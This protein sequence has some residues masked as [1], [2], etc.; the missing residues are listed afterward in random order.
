MA[1]AIAAATDKVTHS[2]VAVTSLTVGAA[3]RR[4]SVIARRLAATVVVKYTVTFPAG[5]TA[6]ALTSAS[7]NNTKLAEQIKS[8]AKAQGLTI[9]VSDVTVQPIVLTSAGGST[10][11]PT[12]SST[13]SETSPSV[14]HF[15]SIGITMVAMMSLMH[16]R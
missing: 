7:M 3:G 13:G 16:S 1:H 11:A 6:P 2:M 15:L 5:V 10:K 12:T 9:T 8:L 14:R 4:L